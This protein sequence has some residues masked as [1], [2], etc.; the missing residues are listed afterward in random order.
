M[1]ELLTRSEWDELEDDHPAREQ[2]ETFE[3]YQ[4]H[5]IAHGALEVAAVAQEYRATA[6]TAGISV[7]ILALR[8]IDE[9]LGPY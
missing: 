9:L 4:R 5:A 8:G 3:E 1:H 6:K 7:G 2:F